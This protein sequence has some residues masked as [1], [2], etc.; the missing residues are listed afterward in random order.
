MR[1][2]VRFLPLWFLVD[3]SECWVTMMNFELALPLS[4]LLLL[5]LLG[6]GGLGNCLLCILSFRGGIEW[7]PW[8]YLDLVRELLVICFLPSKGLSFSLVTPSFVSVGAAEA[9]LI[10]CWIICASCQVFRGGIPLV[11]PPLIFPLFPT[12][13]TGIYTTEGLGLPFLLAKVFDF[14][15]TDNAG[16]CSSSKRSFCRRRRIYISL[17]CNGRQFCSFSV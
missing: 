12:K 4:C 7:N 15:L 6:M 5:L 1:K 17:S 13:L 3:I 16:K 8:P 11:P 14:L 9:G 10:S 2:I